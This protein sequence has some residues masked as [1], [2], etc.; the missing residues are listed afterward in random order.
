MIRRPPRSTLFPYTTLFR[1]P[2]P[3]VLVLDLREPLALDG[4]GDDHGR[5]ARRRQ[6]GAV[7][8][9]DG[10]DVVAVD[11]DRE[12]AERLH[13]AAIRVQRPAVFGLPALA[14]PVYVADAR[15]VL[16]L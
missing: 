6:G 13:P 7:R 14:W 3:A 9:V 12:A 4:L 16:A 2:M 10:G 11:D 15:S 8:A 5:L 1:S